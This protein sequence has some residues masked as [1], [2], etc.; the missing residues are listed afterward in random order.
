MSLVCRMRLNWAPGRLKAAEG[1]TARTVRAVRQGG[2]MRSGLFFCLL[3]VS[4]F[5]GA[6]HAQRV[7]LATGDDNF[8]AEGL[9]RGV[10]ASEAQ[11][12]AVPNAVWARA[13]GGAA[14]CLRYWASGLPASGPLARVLIYISGDQ[15]AFDQ[16]D[17]AYSGR[18]PKIMQGLADGMAAR[19]GVPLILLSRPGTFG[20]SGEHKQRRRELEPRLVSAAL[21]LIKT[22]HAIS[23][24]V[25]VGLSGGG[26]TVAALLGWRSD[27]VCAVPTSSV[28][29]P[30]IRWQSMGRTTDLTGYADSYEPV[31]HLKREIFHRKLRVFVLGDL[32]D[33]NVPWSTQLPLATRLKELG[34]SVELLSGE[35]SDSQRHALGASGR[36]IG[37]LCLQ[38]K[39]TQDIL[40]AA[41]RGLRG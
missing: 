28:S 17:A 5:I 40:Q 6:A 32:R 36:L 1:L 30:K 18:N 13:P 26:H 12:A 41:G 25:L 31:D 39:S 33:S 7:P 23:E 10:S 20:S 9:M 3:L 21:D 16:A 19:A 37:A 8:T 29:S 35:G 4:T 27:I 24:L 38:D 22:R 11:C 15:M 34:A 14:E 2:A